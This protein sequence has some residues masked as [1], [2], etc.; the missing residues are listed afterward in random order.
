M[1]KFLFI[2]ITTAC[3]LNSR[4]QSPNYTLINTTIEPIYTTP[5][6]VMPEY[7]GGMNRFYDRLKSIQYLYYAR[8]QN[9]QGKVMVTMVIEKDGSVS[10]TKIM[11]GFVEE[12]DK[13]I[14]RVV[15]N[16]NKWK[17]GM[18]NGQPVRVAYNVPLNFKLVPIPPRYN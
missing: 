17:P 15:N 12:Q 7:K 14:L 3:A 9:K 2:L 16:L 18:H 13:E 6:E 1:K 11:N 5:V 10:N 4:A 8:M